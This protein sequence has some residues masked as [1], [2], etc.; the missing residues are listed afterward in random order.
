MP[1]EA[2]C[3]GVAPPLRTESTAAWSGGP[4][5]ARSSSRGIGRDTL[6]SRVALLE[7]DMI[8][9]ALKSTRGNLAAA[10]RQLGITARMIRYKIKKL[11]LD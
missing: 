11:G 4:K 10:A 3:S 9:D 1:C 6:T 7:K 8:V 2:A 5:V